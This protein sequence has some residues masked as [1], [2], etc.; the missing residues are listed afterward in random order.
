MATTIDMGGYLHTE[1]HTTT[2]AG[3]W[4]DST[5]VVLDGGEIRVQ[6]RPGVPA[7]ITVEGA[8]YA[9]A[10]QARAMQNAMAHAVATATAYDQI[11]QMELAG[12]VAG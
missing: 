8:V 9:T 6:K 4:K 12:L 10:K 11:E 7:C 5:F 1:E 3:R 2:V